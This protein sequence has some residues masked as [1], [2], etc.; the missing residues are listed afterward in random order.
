MPREFEY[1][2]IVGFEDTNLVGNVYY[3][4]H[5]KW[6][7]R[8]RELFIRE[9]APEILDELAAGLSLAT[10]RCSCEY[11]AELVAFDEIIVRMR[12]TG[13]APTRMSL[14]FEYYRVTGSREELVARGEQ[15]IACLRKAGDRLVPAQIPP[16]LAS[17]LREYAYDAVT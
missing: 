6:Q 14:G 3:V 12:L 17:A 5:L 7:G 15:Q 1:R 8:C 16:S 11:V 13:F 4:N 2:H 10:L 9:H